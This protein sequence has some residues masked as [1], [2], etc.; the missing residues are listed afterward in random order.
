MRELYTQKKHEVKANSLET[1]TFC[2]YTMGMRIRKRGRPPKLAVEKREERLDLRVNAA[3]KAAFKLAAENS[4]QDL[5]VWIR[6]QLHRAAS[7]QL[8]EVAGSKPA[9]LDGVEDG[10]HDQAYTHRSGSV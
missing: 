10:Q 8:T 6:V 9:N 2:V 3:E 5:S 7:E 4:D 1:V